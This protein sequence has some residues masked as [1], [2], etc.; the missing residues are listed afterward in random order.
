MESR[1][2]GIFRLFIIAIF[3][4]MSIFLL[5]NKKSNTIATHIDMNAKSDI[6]INMSLDR[7]YQEMQSLFLSHNINLIV[8][9]MGQLKY[10]LLCEFIQKLIEDEASELSAQEKVKIIY[11]VAIN[12]KRNAQYELLDFFIKYPSLHAQTPILLTLAHSL[13]ADHIPL[14][15]A[16]G[17]DRQKT[18]NRTGLLARYAEQAFAKAVENNDDY[19]VA[20]LFNKKVRIAHAKASELL[21]DIVENNRNG[22]LITLFINHAQADVNYAHQGK[23][24]LIR[25]VELNNID[26]VRILLDKEAVVDRIADEDMATALSVAMKHNY[27]SV[28]QLLR[29]YGA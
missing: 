20:T 12:Q 13:Y 25:A 21:W 23:T 19:A 10:P 22:A 2:S 24:L 27:N 4:C 26:M 17:K 15:I 11:G 14:L 6:E 18:E 3:F 1:Q 9:T 8:K 5:N 29:E 7:I 28:E 16:W